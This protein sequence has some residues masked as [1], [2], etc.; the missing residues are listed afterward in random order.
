MLNRVAQRRPDER[1]Q[2]LVM[3]LAF[4]AFFAV[5]VIAV[6]NFADATGLQHVHTEKTASNDSLAEGGAAWAAADA[7]SDAL[8]CIPGDIGH[9]TMVGGDVASYQIEGCNPG[10]TGQGL[11]GTPCVLCILNQTPIP[12]ATSTSAATTVL[13]YQAASSLKRG[14]VRIVLAKFELPAMPVQIVYPTSRLLSAKVRTFIDLV[15]ET[16][17]WHFG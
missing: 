2:V 6:L 14:H 17:D 4:I 11:S 16:A 1:G 13:A 10:N 8:A 15:T 5:V 9:V 3:A 7:K 12:P